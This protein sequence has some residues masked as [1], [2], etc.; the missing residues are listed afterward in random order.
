MGRTLNLALPIALVAVAGFSAIRQDSHAHGRV[1]TPDVSW[2]ELIGG[3][4]RMHVA[5]ASVDP[6]GD[7]DVDFVKLMLPHHQ[8]AVDMAQTELLYGADPQMRRLAQEIITDQA[9]EI[10]LMQLWQKTH[11]SSSRGSDHPPDGDSVKGK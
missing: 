1:A 9:S 11:G 7:H 6:S 5:M 8:G 3:M 10:Q 2:A 4:N